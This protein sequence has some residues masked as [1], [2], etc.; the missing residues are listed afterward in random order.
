[1]TTKKKNTRGN[2][3]IEDK[4]GNMLFEDHEIEKRWNEY[5][6]ELYHVERDEKPETGNDNGQVILRSEV[7]HVIENLR[8]VKASGTDEISSQ[9]LKALD[10][11]GIKVITKLCNLI[12]ESEHIPDG[13][14][15]SSLL[16][17]PQ[18]NATKCSQHRTISLTR[19][20]LIVL[21]KIITNRNRPSIEQEISQEQNGFMT[22]KGTRE[23]LF[24]IRIITERFLDLGIDL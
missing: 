20:V 7:D 24:N 11:V 3:C 19:H 21:I 12:N 16:R 13:L 2:N 22:G 15:D 8:N 9:M 1:M 10:E 17:I 6:G 5:I 14:N 18:K 23:G 4:D